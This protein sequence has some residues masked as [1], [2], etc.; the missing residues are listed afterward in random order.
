MAIPAA[1]VAAGV[2]LY[3]LLERPLLAWLRTPGTRA[4][5]ATLPSPASAA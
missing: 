3:D 4:G 1:S 5:V 2:V